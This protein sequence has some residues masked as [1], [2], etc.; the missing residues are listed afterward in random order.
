M[1]I[2]KLVIL[3][4]YKKIVLGI[5]IS[6]VSF[7]LSIFIVSKTAISIL[8][9]FGIYILL[10]IIFSIIAAYILYDKSDL[11]KFKKLPNYLNLNDRQT[12]LFIHASFDPASK[13]IQDDFPNLNLTVC[14]IY[15][16]RHQDEPMIEVSKKMFP[17]NSEEIKIDPTKLPFEDNSQDIIFAVTAIHEIL[18]HE[19]RVMFFLE[20]KRV[21]KENG[22]IIVSEQLRNFTNYLFFN[23]GAFHFLNK[24]EWTLAI[25]QSG[26]KIFETKRI[27]PF[28]EMMIIKN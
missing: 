14:D 25:Q 22:I 28:A 6:I 23:I 18:C 3:F 2:T 1:K 9:I 15:E 7:L 12:G 24:K 19:K 8:V 13:Q 5:C 16:N 4:N 20:T 21:L 27:T 10:N 17:P 11:Y 26:L